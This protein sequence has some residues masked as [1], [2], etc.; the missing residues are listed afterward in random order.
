[1]KYEIVFTP[2][3]R[4][5]LSELCDHIAQHG[6]PARAL[7]YIARIEKACMSLQTLPH[8]GTLREDVRPGLRLIGFEHRTLIAFRVKG[9]SVA[10]LRILYGG[11]SLERVFAKPAE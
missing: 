2:E 6:S 11:R 5:D 4:D 7:S 3:A 1:V 9:R 10:I 8:R